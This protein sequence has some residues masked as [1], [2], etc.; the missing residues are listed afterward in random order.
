MLPPTRALCGAVLTSYRKD[1]VYGIY[2]FCLS[3]AERGNTPL[4]VCR[5]THCTCACACICAC[6]CA[7]YHTHEPSN[8]LPYPWS[9]LHT[10]RTQKFKHTD[11]NTMQAIG[12]STG[13]HSSVLPTIGGGP[14]P[15]AF[16]H[17]L[18]RAARLEHSLL[19]SARGDCLALLKDR[20]SRGPH[21]ERAGLQLCDLLRTC[22][23]IAV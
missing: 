4:Y 17:P 6:A 15:A 22:I 3:L 8:T 11:T 9:S 12:A 19:L 10:S 16:V 14:D 1:I 18:A 7:P 20:P 5:Y 21:G 2:A 23:G 13:L